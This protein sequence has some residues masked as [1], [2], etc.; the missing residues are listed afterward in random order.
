M[1]RLLDI[2]TNV[3]IVSA[4]VGGTVTLV[5]L[6]VFGTYKAWRE[7]IAKMFK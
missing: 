6:I 7:F 1:K 3:R 5:F 4:E 2:L